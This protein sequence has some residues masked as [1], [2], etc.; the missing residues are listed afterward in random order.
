MKHTIYTILTI[1]TILTT[2]AILAIL[3][4]LAIPTILTILPR[5]L[6]LD[7]SCFHKDSEKWRMLTMR[8]KRAGLIREWAPSR[9]AWKGLDCAHDLQEARR[10]VEQKEQTNKNYS[11]AASMLLGRACSNLLLLL[12]G[13]LYL[14]EAVLRPL[15]ALLISPI[16]YHLLTRLAVETAACGA[17]EEGEEVEARYGSSLEE[18]RPAQVRRANGDGS[19]DLTCGDQ[20]KDGDEGERT[21]VRRYRIRRKGDVE[22]LTFEW[23]QEVD[24]LDGET[25]SEYDNKPNAARISKINELLDGKPKMAAKINDRRSYDVLLLE[26]SKEK[27]GVQALQPGSDERQ[28]FGRCRDGEKKSNSERRSETGVT[29]SRTALQTGRRATPSKPTRSRSSIVNGRRQER[30]VHR[31][32]S[33]SCKHEPEKCWNEYLIQCVWDEPGLNER[34][35]VYYTPDFN[36]KIEAKFTKQDADYDQRIAR[37]EHQNADI[38]HASLSPFPSL[39]EWVNWGESSAAPAASAEHCETPP[40]AVTSNPMVVNEGICSTAV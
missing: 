39:R 10:R 20:D 37:D 15:F 9:G 22:P 23:G 5:R 2:L 30:K 25:D 31:H 17:L 26:S 19:Y 4:K 34:N 14:L 6:H 33:Y 35:H 28:I 36:H 3:A 24:V 12:R 13:P 27:A 11:S 1:C 18:W 40:A 7:D 16:L 32:C 21:G 29:L 8:A 38:A